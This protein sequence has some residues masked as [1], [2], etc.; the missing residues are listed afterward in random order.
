MSVPKGE[1]AKRR[2]GLPGQPPKTAS[3]KQ[4]QPRT[5]LQSSAASPERQ[6]AGSLGAEDCSSPAA[7]QPTRAGQQE[8]SRCEELTVEIGRALRTRVT[9]AGH[10]R[11]TTGTNTTQAAE[12]R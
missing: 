3:T 1:E 10:L 9:Q 4:A 6:R 7:K 8:G 11:S 5:M 2:L 12:L